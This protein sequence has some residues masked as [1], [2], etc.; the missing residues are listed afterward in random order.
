MKFSNSSDGTQNS[1]AALLASFSCSG[2]FSSFSYSLEE[3]TENGY[4]SLRAYVSV[5]VDQSTTGQL[6]ISFKPRAIEAAG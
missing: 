4:P 5:A 3:L 6:L 2:R 1:A